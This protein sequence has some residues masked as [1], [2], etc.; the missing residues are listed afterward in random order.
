MHIE[1]I[2]PLGGD[3]LENLCL[4]CSNCNLSKAR[5]TYAFDPAT[6]QFVPLFNPRT[7]VWAEHF[8]WSENGELLLG[9]TPT[10]RA[11]ISR[12][13]MNQDRMI[14]ARKRWIE[15]GYHPPH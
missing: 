8:R 2:D 13:K 1:H 15:A 12:L 5:A 7:Q 11:T 9:L 4:A 6:N 14:T 10:G 3:G